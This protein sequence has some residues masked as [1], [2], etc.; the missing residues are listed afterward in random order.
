MPYVQLEHWL[1]RGAIKAW[2]GFSWKTFGGL[3][4]GA[5]VGLQLGTLVYGSGSAGQVGLLAA[6]AVLGLLIML[7]RRGM[8]AGK[9]LLILL[10]FGLRVLRGHTE[11]D[12]RAYGIVAEEP[13]P[14]P[15]IRV[16]VRQ[17]PSPL[18]GP[19][20]MDAAPP[21]TSAGRLLGDAVVPPHA[22]EELTP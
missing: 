3:A 6:G 13:D 21:G 22:I 7:Q 16:R 17:Q 8:I 1:D 11:I 20:P 12:G 9:R 5:V 19:T 15:L 10:Q 18:A 14:A 2:W 4:V